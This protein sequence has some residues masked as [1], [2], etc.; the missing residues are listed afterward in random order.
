[1][2]GFKEYGDY[3][4]LGLA[5]LVKLKVISPLELVEEAISRIESVNPKLNAVI[6]PMYEEAKR[7]AES[8]L[9][10]GPFTGVPFLLK[11]LLGTYAGVRFT[12][13]CKAYEHYIPNHDAEIVKRFKAAGLI[14]L[15]KTNTP[16]FGLMGV[17]EPKLFGPTLNPWNT[18]HTP[19]GSSGGSAAAVASGMVPM[20]S[21]GDGGGSIRIPASC[22]G[23]FGIKPSRGR[24]PL[25]PDHGES[26]QGAVVDHVVSRT[27]RDSAAMLDA[28]CGPSSGDPY[29]IKPPA[30]SYMAE[31]LKQP[32]KLKIAYSTQ[33][34][35]GTLV[36]RECVN[37]V[38]KAVDL[39][40][41]LGHHVIE[42]QPEYDGM[43]LAKAYLMIYFGEVA[44]DIAQIESDIGR[45]ARCE[46]VE[47]ATWTIGLL[48]RA[49]SARDF[50]ISKRTWND[51][52]R[53][54]GT[55]HEKYDLY[56]TPTLAAPPVKTGELQPNFL[57]AMG[58]KVINKIEL[59]GH[60]LKH[61]GFIE[62]LAHKSFEKL[63]FTQLAN[64]TGQPAMSVPLH[65]SES[66]L[67]CGVQFIAKMGDEATL[68]RLAAQLEKAAPW[69]DHRPPIH[70]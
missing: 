10:E 22:C 6:T 2:S 50:V 59:G 47:D 39:L 58:A 38:E 26:W 45:P 13:G 44:A 43:A 25:G 19:G 7:I 51:F 56:L 66:G 54:M 15:G 11:D 31:I 69:K 53:A 62:Q 68:F 27:V 41:N 17:T 35:L 20:A 14:T 1:M 70:A 40:R 46:D 4:G 67:P 48:G 52:A 32:G 63:P 64:L 34:P 12:K 3:D 49:Y 61:T 28:V 29:L 16:E 9:P 24:T 21:A 60:I 65:W 42:Q 57:E 55:F 33:S 36:D 18:A 23:I 8:P 5:E 30:H 37:A